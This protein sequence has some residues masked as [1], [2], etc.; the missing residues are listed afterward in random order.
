MLTRIVLWWSAFTSLT[1][2]VAS[3]PVAAAGPLLFGMG[4]AGAYPNASIVIA[5]WIPSQHAGPRLGAD[6]DDQSG[7]RRRSSPLLVVPHQTRY[8]WRAAFFVFGMRRRGVGGRLVL[9][10]SRLAAR[11]ARRDA[12]RAPRDRQRPRTERH[13]GLPWRRALADG[14]FWRIALIGASYVY[15]L[16]F[17]QSW[18]QT[19]LV[20]GRGYTEAALVLSSLPYVLGARGQR[21]GGLLSDALVRRWGAE[22]RPPHGRRGG[23]RLRRRVHGRDHRDHQQCVGARRSCRWP[24][25][26]SCV[27]QPNLCAVCLDTGRQHAGAVFGFMNTAAQVAAV[28]SSLAFG[29]LVGYSGNYNVPFIPMVATLSIG[30]MLWLKIDPT[31]Q[32]FEEVEPAPTVTLRGSRRHD[33][34][35]ALSISQFLDAWRIFGRACPGSR[36]ESAAGVDYM[37]TGLPIAFFNVAVLTSDRLSAVALDT[38]AR[39]AMQWASDKNAPWLFIVTHEAL[40]AGTDAAAVLDACGLGPAP[41][42]DRD[43][44]RADCRRPPTVPAGLQLEVPEDDGGC[45]DIIDV[46]SAAYGMDLAASKPAFGRGAFWADHVAV[47]GRAGGAPATSAA[48]MLAGGH[49]YVAL[50]ATQPTHQKRGFAEAAMRHALSVAADKFGERPTFLHATDAGRP[51]YARMGYEAVAERTPASSTSGSWPAT[52]RDT[53]TRWMTRR[54]V[55]AGRG[56]R[57]VRLCAPRPESNDHWDFIADAVGL[58]AVSGEEPDLPRAVSAGLRPPARGAAR[59]AHGRRVRG[60][61]R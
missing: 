15:A 3:Y 1:G 49:R 24:T 60:V 58:V 11:E 50:V 22:G 35:V 19:Y 38:S 20:R 45:G 57:A 46:N 43:D 56:R 55:D 6:L 17:F 37:F 10:V 16:T 29:Y 4:E 33:R 28:A 41:A 48:V 59:S 39:G 2:M 5:R 42:V 18:L 44:S 26:A 51:I 30:A 34:S 21:R 54:L 52:E 8:G 31:H 12:G 53:I 61:R 9:V 40:E 32:L 23:A 14:T 13:G 25:P 27:Q 36:V 47:L 7:R